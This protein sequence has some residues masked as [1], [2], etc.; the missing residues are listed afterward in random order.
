MMKQFFNK[1]KKET[2]EE[3]IQREKEEQLLKEKQART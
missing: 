3:R 2:E 1:L